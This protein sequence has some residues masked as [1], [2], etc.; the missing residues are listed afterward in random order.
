V[1]VRS[2]GSAGAVGAPITIGAN[3]AVSPTQVSVAV[4]QS[5]TFT[6]N[7]TQSHDMESDPHPEHTNCPSIANVGLLQPGQSKPRSLRQQR[8][9]QVLIT[10]IR[11]HDPGANRRR[12]FEAG[13]NLTT[14]GVP[15]DSRAR[16][17]RFLPSHVAIQTAG[18]R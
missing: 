15:Q 16:L 2:T 5:V 17:R 9:L 7:S 3:G 12:S 10:T 6:N 1:I 4:G 8:E 11:V 14:T 18:L 13:S